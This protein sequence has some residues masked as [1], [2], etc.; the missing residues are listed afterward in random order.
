[1]QPWR[2][3]TPAGRTARVEGD[4]RLGSYD[5][6]AATGGETRSPHIELTAYQIVL[7][8]AG[9]AGCAIYSHRAGVR[10]GQTS[11]DRRSCRF[12]L[13]RCGESA[14]SR[15]RS[16]PRLA[17]DCRRFWTPGRPHWEIG[18]L[19]RQAVRLGRASLP[20]QA[21]R[22]RQSRCFFSSPTVL[23]A[24]APLPYQSS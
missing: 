5:G 14:W 8:L 1:V 9:R 6:P 12:R 19:L 23:A 13:R 17:T 20:S 15:A 10:P 18:L 24:L 4:P 3:I 11:A 22:R 2:R 16:G 7:T 21:V